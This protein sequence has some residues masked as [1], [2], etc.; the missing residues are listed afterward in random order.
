MPQAATLITA[1]Y[2][3]HARDLPWRQT[4]D[5]YRIWLSETLLQQTRIATGTAYYHRFL[6][7]F[8]SLD[9]LANAPEADVLKQWEGLGYYSRARN[10]LRAAHIIH[11][12]L[13][14]Q[15]PQTV[16]ALQAL[17]G[18]G[19]YTARAVASIAF[20]V[21]AAVLD[22]NVFR[23]LSR[24]HADATP[25]DSPAARPHYQR[26]ADDT[27]GSDA[28]PAAYNQAIMDI[29]ATI[30][31]PK[32]PL[33]A[34][35]PLQAICQAYL[36][37]T[38]DRYPVKGKRKA[39]PQRW[40]DILL[41]EDDTRLVVRQRTET[42]LWQGLWELPWQEVPGFDTPP[43]AGTEWHRLTHQFTHFTLHLRVSHLPLA[44][45]ELQPGDTPITWDKINQLAFNRAALR[46]IQA[47]QE[48]QHTP[49][50]F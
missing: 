25:I 31:L 14:G 23:V 6:E 3:R 24:L 21:R 42:R 20:G 38:T 26:L 27:L 35:C 4:R 10:L 7:R 47:W 5:P 9:Q 45:Y 39:V 16:E 36:T 37:E 17:P 19:P 13:Q 12:D 32:Q 50:L 46:I 43:T 34:K 41:V 48:R 11:H 29:G 18:I 28:A 8:P 44:L 1:W 2:A 40:Q 22:G 15:F 30:C 49:R 33:C